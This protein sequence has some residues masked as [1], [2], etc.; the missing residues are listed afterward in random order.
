M[1]SSHDNWEV[2]RSCQLWIETMIKTNDICE[3]IARAGAAKGFF[4]DFVF[5]ARLFR[6]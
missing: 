1:P 3:A 4:V 2:G 6:R 5:L